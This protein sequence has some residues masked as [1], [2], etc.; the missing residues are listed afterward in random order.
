MGVRAKQLHFK[1]LRGYF[2]VA[3]IRFRITLSP[4]LDSLGAFP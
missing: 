3:S 4:A 2:Y 1:I